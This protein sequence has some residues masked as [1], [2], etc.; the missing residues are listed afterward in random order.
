VT[1]LPFFRALVQQLCAVLHVRY[2]FVAECLPNLRARSRAF[3]NGDGLGEDFEYDLPGTPCLEVARGRTYHC[4]ARLPEVFPDDTGMIA[5]GTQSYLG[6]PLLDSSHRV[7]GHLVIFDTKP[8]P[9]DS[10]T[11]TVMELFAS[12]AGAELE[13]VRVAEELQARDQEL[14]TLLDVNVA[15][16]RHL[17]RDDLFGALASC[18]RTVLKTDHFGIE[19]PIEGQRLQGHLMSPRGSKPEPTQST[20]LPAEG[21]ACNWVIQHH[22]WFV[23]HGRDEL[24]DRFPVTFEVMARERMESLC[25][26]PLTTD[27]R[28]LGALFFM[29]AQKGAYAAV[30]RELLDQV[31]SAV[32]VAL[33]GCLAHEE[34]QRLRD[35]LQV[36]NRYLQEEIRAEHNFHEIVGK[37]PVVLAMLQRIEQVAPSESTVLLLGETGT[38][39]EVV[40]R[41]LHDRSRRRDRPFVKVNCAALSAGLV[42]SEL[43]GHVKGAF[44]GALTHR[45]G[46]FKVASSG[47]ILL[48]EV[49]EVPRETQVK[50]LRVLQ[51]REFE[52]IGSSKSLRTDVRVIAATNRDLAEAVRIGTFRSDL[53]YRLNVVPITVPPLR[54]RPTD[55][56]LLVT[57]FLERYAKRLGKQ[58]DRVSEEVMNRLCSYAWPG[59]V[60]ELQNVIERAVILSPGLA[61]VLDHELQSAPSGSREPADLGRPSSLSLEEMERRHILSVLAT[62]AGVIEGPKGAATIL[63]LHPNTLRSRMQKL[64][65]RR[66]RGASA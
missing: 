3:W 62:T 46:R 23:A 64:G 28:V 9:A 49:G 8:M 41:A 6:V 38:G 7:I 29:A 5:L 58:I 60:R 13:R 48:D 63:N 35:Q 34:V 14:K 31:A 54:E 10:P 59:N 19:L 66:P 15:I 26:L 36:E 24:R 18:L 4:P 50:L 52:P 1:G 21:T 65:I 17:K 44:T 11:L 20:V 39:K 56:P 2:A 43:F 47:T 33:D 61:L 25:A 42:E 32:A 16:G 57:F 37:S 51:E 30:R 55:I 40:A 12:R 22:Q 45:D 27:E 53:F